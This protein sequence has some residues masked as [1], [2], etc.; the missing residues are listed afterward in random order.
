MLEK[1]RRGICDEASVEL[2]KTCGTDLNGSIKIRVSFFPFLFKNCYVSEAFR[3]F[4]SQRTCI[5]IKMPWIVRMRENLGDW[6]DLNIR[7]RLLIP[8]MDLELLK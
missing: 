2:L 3:V 5:L 4:H 8:P 1:F 7:S 6:S